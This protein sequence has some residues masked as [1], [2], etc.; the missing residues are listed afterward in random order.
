MPAAT[1]KVTF[2]RPEL[3]L[4][5]AMCVCH[6]SCGFVVFKNSSRNKYVNVKNSFQLCAKFVC[7]MPFKVY[8]TMDSIPI[9]LL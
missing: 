5:G 6:H 7:R 8:N 2:A 4:M 1:S 9:Q 3:S